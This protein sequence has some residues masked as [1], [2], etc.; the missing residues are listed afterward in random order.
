MKKPIRAV[1]RARPEPEVDADFIKLV[2]AF[3]H[4]PEVSRGKMFG[5]TGLKVNGKVFAML[6]KGNFVAKLPK[7]RVDELV[8]AGDGRYFE[9]GH[10]RLM[11]EWISLSVDKREW[12]KFAEEACRFV[13]KGAR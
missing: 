2:E 9:P 11:K 1:A 10:G 3:S 13:R 4:N 6:T 5:S 8:A 12:L 7:E